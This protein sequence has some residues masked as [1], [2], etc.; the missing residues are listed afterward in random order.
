M[1]FNK[2]HA[3]RATEDGLVFDSGKEV[4]RYRELKLLVRAGEIDSLLVHPKYA[5]EI[6][7]S[8]ILLRSKGYPNGRKASYKPDFFYVDR[9]S[10]KPTVEDVKSEATRTEAYV[11]RRG[12]FEALYP[13]IKFIEL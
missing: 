5:L 7:G 11:L 9:A 3:K 4:K 12:I 13:Q 6:N 1:T 8:P 10:G 2:Y